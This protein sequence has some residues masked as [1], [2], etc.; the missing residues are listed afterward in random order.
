MKH[1]GHVLWFRRYV[2]WKKVDPEFKSRHGH[3]VISENSCGYQSATALFWNYVKYDGF[4]SCSAQLVL[5]GED[6]FGLS[7]ASERAVVWRSRSAFWVTFMLLQSTQEV[8]FTNNLGLRRLE[9]WKNCWMDDRIV[10]FACQLSLCTLQ[11]EIKG[12]EWPI[13]RISAPMQS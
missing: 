3:C 8:S 10:L 2:E 6:Y 4:D 1:W 13:N 11:N 7:F 12:K 5:H 9:I